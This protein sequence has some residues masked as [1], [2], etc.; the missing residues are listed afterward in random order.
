[1]FVLS[2][3]LCLLRDVGTLW[4][5]GEYI[6][7]ELLQIKTIQEYSR[8]RHNVIFSFRGSWQPDRQQTNLFLKTRLWCE[9]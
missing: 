2:G 5:Y 8:N 4:E 6:A 7:V 1:V 9:N 3:N